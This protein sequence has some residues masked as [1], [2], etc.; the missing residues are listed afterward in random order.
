MIYMTTHMKLY[1]NIWKYMIYMTIYM[2]YMTIYMNLYDNILKYMKLY[3]N[4]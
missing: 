3:D 1:D 2:I 4:I